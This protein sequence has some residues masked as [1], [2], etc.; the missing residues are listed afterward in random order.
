MSDFVTALIEGAMVGS[1]MFILF[2]ILAFI[3]Q[4]IKKGKK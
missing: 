2:L 3:R 4:K 1:M